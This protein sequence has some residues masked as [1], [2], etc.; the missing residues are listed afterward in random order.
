M[1]VPAT[2]LEFNNLSKIYQNRI[3]LGFQNAGTVGEYLLNHPD[4]TFDAKIASVF[5][6]KYD[7]LKMGQLIGARTANFINLPG[8]HERACL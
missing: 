4:P 1:V 8:Q 6:G 7:E 5:K 3:R 2:K